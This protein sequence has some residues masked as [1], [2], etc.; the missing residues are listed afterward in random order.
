M[1][2]EQL[3]SGHM[4]VAV[5]LMAEKL[6]FVVD[7]GASITV[8]TPATRKM[9]GLDEDSDQKLNIMGP[10]G[11]LQR[12][13]LQVIDRLALG[14]TEH[15]DL[16][17][18]EMDLPQVKNKEGKPIAGILGQNFF[19][20]HDLVIDFS[21]MQL[22]IHPKGTFAKD[23][24]DL[25][26]Y[27]A[28]SF[29]LAAE[30]ML[31]SAKVDKH[32]AIPALLDMG[33]TRTIIN[34]AAAVILGA[35][36]GAKNMLAIEVNRGVDNTRFPCRVYRFE[37]LQLG[38]WQT[39]KP[40]IQACNLPLFYETGMQKVPAIILGLNLFKDKRLVISFAEK[41]LWISDRANPSP[42]T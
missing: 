26:E 11:Q 40:I 29:R 35:L 32:M 33:S 27:T 21:N 2:L 9:L 20:Q 25:K 19:M 14:K 10:G 38:E 28:V 18:V 4:I 3:T 34:D 24:E 15:I 37:T 1:A 6:P 36:P 31:F 39:V 41:I 8:I 17:A 23:S 7:T 16:Q 12:T 42:Q 13:N 22:E 30:N 5:G